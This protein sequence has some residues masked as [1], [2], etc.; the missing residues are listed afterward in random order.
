MFWNKVQLKKKYHIFIR[1]SNFG[2]TMH[3]ECILPIFMYAP[4]AQKIAIAQND[5]VM[6]TCSKLIAMFLNSLLGLLGPV[7]II[8]CLKLSSW[9]IV[10][11][12]WVID[13]GFQIVMLSTWWSAVSW[14]VTRHWFSLFLDVLKAT[15]PFQRLDCITNNEI[16]L[17][18][19]SPI[20]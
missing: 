6:A 1:T 14:L 8:S 16:F 7:F 18:T 4:S 20:W 2:F 12:Y 15:F 13:S 10:S 9:K 3:Y 17:F 11:K 19:S 5:P